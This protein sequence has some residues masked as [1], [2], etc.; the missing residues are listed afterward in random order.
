MEDLGNRQE[1]E[2]RADHRKGPLHLIKWYRLIL[3]EAH[4]IKNYL[5]KQSQACRALDAQHYWAVT[6]T[7]LV[8]S[9]KE[10]FSYFNLL[11]MPESDSYLKFSKQYLENK[12]FQLKVELERLMIKRTYLDRILGSPIAPI[13]STT[14]IDI[15]VHP[16][17]VEKY[18][19]QKISALYRKRI[20][21]LRSKGGLSELEK[22]KRVMGMLQ[23]VLQLTRH[24]LLAQAAVG[25]E[26]R[27]DIEDLAREAL[28]QSSSRVISAVVNKV[29][30][31]AH[32]I[33]MALAEYRRRI[34]MFSSLRIEKQRE[35]HESGLP[36]PRKYKDDSLKPPKTGF[37][38][39]EWENKKLPLFQSSKT[40]A[41]LDEVEK[42]LSQDP[43]RKILVFTLSRGVIEILR[44]AFSKKRWRH[45]I[46]HGGMT[47]EQRE[48]AINGFNKDQTKM[49]MI[50]SMFAGGEG[51]NLEVASCVIMVDLWWNLA[52][53]RQAQMRIIRISQ[54]K[55]TEV[56]RLVLKGT[57]D[58]HLL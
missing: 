14:K 17:P 10:A 4:A 43:T 58:E 55:E 35:Y 34:D 26:E 20:Q 46:Y 40:Q 39:K 57:I 53:E 11:R 22:R 13:P 38:V 1:W 23:R 8:N 44:R 54:T 7:P 48:R 56:V 29:I 30:H 27:D 36:V 2:R 12:N 41:V 32:E 33:Q 37:S 15:P 18:I 9:H 3:D 51:L 5:A 19:L 28:P 25:L 50:M 6:A 45:E 21:A 16:Y 31:N 47:N 52:K 49:V 24:W 42:R